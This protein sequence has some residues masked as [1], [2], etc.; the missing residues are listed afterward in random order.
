MRARSCVAAMLLA[1]CA[2][3]AQPAAA[4]PSEEA[5]R[6]CSEAIENWRRTCEARGGSSC[7]EAAIQL[8]AEVCP[9][10]GSRELVRRQLEKLREQR[11]LRP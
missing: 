8:Q 3:G 6:K 5:V 4:D 10:G 11:P 1:A 9:L 2:G 7:T